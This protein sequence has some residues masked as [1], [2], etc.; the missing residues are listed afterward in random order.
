[1]GAVITVATELAGG[2]VF[3]ILRFASSQECEPGDYVQL[4]FDGCGVSGGMGW[5]ITSGDHVNAW[6]AEK[7]NGVFHPGS[8]GIGLMRDGVMRAGVMF[9]NWN[10]KSVMAHM[11]VDGGRLTPAYVAAIFDYA[12]NVCGVE[13]VILP[14]GSQNLKSQRL[15]ENMGFMEEGRILDAA[16]DGDIVIYTMSKP[17]CRFLGEKYGKK[18]TTAAARA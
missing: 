2:W 3:R 5:N 10:G 7:I 8:V 14:V 11:A 6:V 16:P 1:M 18:C 15:V 13:K 12:Y 9:E 17:D 4:G